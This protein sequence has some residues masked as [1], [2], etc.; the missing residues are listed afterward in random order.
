M[1]NIAE[2]GRTVLFVSHDMGAIINLCP[3]TILLDKG[4]IIGN[5]PTNKIVND[6]EH[7]M[8]N[9]TQNIPLAERKDRKGKG[10]IKLIGIQ[11]LDK[12]YKQIPYAL[13]GQTLIIEL[14]YEAERDLPDT[15][16]TI[17]FR[18]ASGGT[19]FLCSATHDVGPFNVSRGKGKV[20]C[21][22][23]SLDLVEGVYSLNLAIS[24][25]ESMNDWIK[26]AYTLSVKTIDFYGNEV[27]A[28][29]NHS[30]LLVRSYWSNRPE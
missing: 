28:N 15:D 21:K 23:P 19:L 14:A 8:L 3:R 26:S 5:G 6:F 18:T 17:G 29:K 24:R 22:I 12:A 7:A 4:K 10:E 30:P 9:F 25:Y 27:Q 1:E 20:Y 13:S 2:H 11:I 16:F